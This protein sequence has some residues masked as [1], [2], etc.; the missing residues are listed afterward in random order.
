MQEYAE[1]SV[2]LRRAKFPGSDDDEDRGGRRNGRS[3]DLSQIGDGRER[4]RVVFAMNAWN[5]TARHDTN[6]TDS[7]KRRMRARM[8]CVVRWLN[9]Y[10]LCFNTYANDIF[11]FD[12]LFYSKRRGM[13]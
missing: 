10:I 11:V 12:S 2:R 8:D 4:E 7:G 3:D 5:M 6:Q 13:A 1:N 9:D